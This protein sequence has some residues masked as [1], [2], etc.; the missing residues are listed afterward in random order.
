MAGPM[1]DVDK[2]LEKLI[3]VWGPESHNGLYPTA[4]QWRIFLESPHTGRVVTV[5]FAKFRAPA[6]E[7]EGRALE[8][9]GNAY[10]EVSARLQQ[11]MPVE[12]LYGGKFSG[13]LFGEE[14]E[15]WDGVYVM[16][17]PSREALL[18]SLWLNPEYIKV[19]LVQKPLALEKY[20]LI[21]TEPEAE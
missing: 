20:K 12:I 7:E 2:T 1:E 21:V 6:N 11:E 16:R 8:A 9:A 17:F 18:K 4:R 3:S 15:D 5:Q 10:V 19:A 13:V 14:A